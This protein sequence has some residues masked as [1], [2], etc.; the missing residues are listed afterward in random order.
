MMIENFFERPHAL[1]R[2]RSSC[3]GPYIDTFATSLLAEGYTFNRGRSLLRGVSL[4]GYWLDEQGI[5]LAALDEALLKQF[6]IEVKSCARGDGKPGYC[7]AGGHHFLVWARVR[8]IVS[9]LCPN[10]SVPML[11][12]T[13][14]TWMVQHRNVTAVTL[15]NYRLP[16]R[17]FLGALGDDPSQFGAADI[18]QFIIAESRRA[19]RGYAKLVVTAVRMFLRYLATVGRCAPLLVDAVPT[20][21]NWKISALPA[22]LSRKDVDRI[23]GACDLTTAGGCRN[24]AMILLMARLGLRSGDVV[25]LRL[26]DIDWKNATLTVFGKGRRA[27]RMPLP[28]DVGDA[29]LC[30]LD[31]G[32]PERDDLHV[33]LRLRAPY[34]PLTNAAVHAVVD[35]VAK[36]VGVSAPHVGPNMLRHSAAVALLKE[37]ASL[38]AIGAILRHKHLDTT[39]IY[40]KVD[41]NLLG[42]VARPWPVEVSK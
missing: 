31:T 29:L 14:Q 33:F 24:R 16:L 42:T 11:I 9:T 36:R 2:L 21:A 39:T 7:R 19:E 30:W 6:I 23:I 40:A 25:K 20:I 38:P 4:L 13:F 17:R 3:T 28:Q 35:C 12:S 8:R 15:Q 10:A 5:E 27:T 26:R 41:S 22:Y 18:R 37:G 1:R 34:C 32:R